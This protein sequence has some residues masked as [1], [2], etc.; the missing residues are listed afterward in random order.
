[1]LRRSYQDYVARRIHRKL[2]KLQ[3]LRQKTLLIGIVIGQK[4]LTPSIILLHQIRL[5]LNL[6]LQML[7]SATISDGNSLK[8]LLRS[9]F[10]HVV[11]LQ[12][13]HHLYVLHQLL[14]GPYANSKINYFNYCLHLRK[15]LLRQSL[16]ARLHRLRSL[17][18]IRKRCYKLRL[19][20]MLVALVVY[21]LSVKL[22][23]VAQ[24]GLKTQ[25]R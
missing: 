17:H 7:S 19:Q 18:S 22:V 23:K 4:S 25:E 8:L 14:S 16:K 13:H 9:S 5:P 20:R 3:Q 15:L 21:Y 2:L 1:M 24:L 10:G 12:R 6:Y 11:V